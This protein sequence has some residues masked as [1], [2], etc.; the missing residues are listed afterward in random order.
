MPPQKLKSFC[1]NI[2]AF[3]FDFGCSG[4]LPAF[5]FDLRTLNSEACEDLNFPKNFKFGYAFNRIASVNI[6]GLVC[7]AVENLQKFDL[8]HLNADIEGQ[9]F[10]SGSM[11]PKKQ[12]YSQTEHR[13]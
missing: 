1:E 12:T 13:A 8:L 4:N 10:I 3:Y 7:K 6:E 9:R 5:T 11:F 2:T